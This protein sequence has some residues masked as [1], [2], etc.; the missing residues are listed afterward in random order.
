MLFDPFKQELGKCI[1]T[2]TDYYLMLLDLAINRTEYTS[3]PKGIDIRYLEK[4]LA[5]NGSCILFKNDGKGE[6]PA[7]KYPFLCLPLANEYSLDSYGE[8]LKRSAIGLNHTY[9]GLT[10]YNSVIM[11]N[12]RLHSSSVPMLRWYSMRMYKAT[13][14]ADANIDMQRYSVIV[15]AREKTRLS[16]L[17]AIKKFQLGLPF[18]FSTADN[19]ISQKD[20]ETLNFNIPYVADKCFSYNRELWNEC[21]TRLGI[22]T[23]N[24]NKK[25]RLLDSEVDSQKSSIEIYRQSY[26]NERKEAV[27]KFNEIFGTEW[28]VEWYNGTLYNDIE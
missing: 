15:K 27:K 12:N 2:E 18:I 23:L 22:D 11:Y 10:P 25:E 13:S 20:F 5:E 8:P 24:I 19:G 26:L 28:G 4:T 1:F 9:T 16:F 17:N 21:L 7:E 6:F 3:T 14:N